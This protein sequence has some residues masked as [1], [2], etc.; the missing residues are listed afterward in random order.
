MSDALHAHVPNHPVAAA[1]FSEP[2]ETLRQ[3][4]IA[5]MRLASRHRSWS[6]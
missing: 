6:G 2:Y 1:N 4:H 3:R 5:D